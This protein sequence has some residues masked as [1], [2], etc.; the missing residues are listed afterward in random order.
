MKR[1][2][3]R[4]LRKSDR[5]I[6]RAVL[7]FV[8]W[9]FAIMA[10]LFVL[11]AVALGATNSDLLL[12][13]GTE[14]MGI[15]ITVLVINEYYDLRGRSELKM[16]LIREMG[17]RDNSDALKAVRELSAHEW[18]SDGSLIGKDFSHAD[19]SDVD[20]KDSDLRESS[21]VCTSFRNAWLSR[22]QLCNAVLYHAM[23]ED[24]ILNAANFIG[25]KFSNIDEQLKEARFMVGAVMPDGEG[26]DG[27]YRLKD[28]EAIIDSKKPKNAIDDSWRASVAAEYYGVSIEKYIAGQ[29]WANENLFPFF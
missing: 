12:N 22:A 1:S 7:K 26:Y 28:D 5:D 20:L 24:A 25:A 13:V 15:V 11:F 6:N 2:L 16:K 19:L 21:L 4:I 14:I 23:F 29:R 10:I 18:L 27:R 8:I 3:E 9:V 17:S